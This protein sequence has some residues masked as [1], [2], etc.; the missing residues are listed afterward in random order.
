V[1]GPNRTNRGR[2]A[3]TRAERGGDGARDRGLREL[4]GAG[5]TQVSGDR[6]LRARDLN[7]PT[8]EDL[9]AAEAEVVVV[10]RHW[11]PRN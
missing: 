3:R 5:P 7:R 9:A 10:R 4:V 2:S 8:D 6:A 11:K 1:A